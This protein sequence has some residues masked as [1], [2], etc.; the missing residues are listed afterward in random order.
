[1]RRIRT[2]SC[3]KDPPP[4]SPSPPP[5]WH[6]VVVVAMDTVAAAVVVVAAAVVASGDDCPTKIVDA[7][8]SEPY[9]RRVF[10]AFWVEH[11]DHYLGDDHDHNEL[12][13]LV[14][15]DAIM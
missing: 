14:L 5:R 6:C 2:G 13:E 8:A 9:R 4:P 11:P 12:V 7:E 1:M 15:I 3:E 10:A